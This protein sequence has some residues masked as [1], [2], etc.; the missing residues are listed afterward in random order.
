[1]I[2]QKSEI[3]NYTAAEAWN[4]AVEYYTI[5]QENYI[6]NIATVNKLELY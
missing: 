6:I 5:Q 4:L 2:S 3:I 1:V